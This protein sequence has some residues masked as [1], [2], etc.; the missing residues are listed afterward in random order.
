MNL[1]PE[2]ENWLSESGWHRDRRVEVASV[3]PK[4]HPA[5]AV[6]ESLDGLSLYQTRDSGSNADPICEIRFTPLDFEA[7]DIH[8][9][10]QTLRTE[11]IG[12]GG[13]HNDHEQV[14]VDSAGRIF[15]A[16]LIHDAFYFRGDSI[17][18]YLLGLMS[19]R[20]ARPML[21]PS[22]TTVMLYGVQ[23]SRDDPEVYPNANW[24]G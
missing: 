9:W 21:R 20:R 24:A 16:S 14:F 10:S 22:Q 5:H 15:A 23:Y 8:G 6:L 18:D 12:I 3:V 7:T 1:A 17:N 13:G 2:I 4:A 19:G 11:L